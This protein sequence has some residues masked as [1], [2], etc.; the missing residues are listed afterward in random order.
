MKRKWSGTQKLNNHTALQ[1]TVK[2][3]VK[4]LECNLV[5]SPL[6]HA[7]ESPWSGFANTKPPSPG[8]CSTNRSLN[9]NMNNKVRDRACVTQNKLQNTSASFPKYVLC[10]NIQYF[11]DVRNMNRILFLAMTHRLHLDFSLFL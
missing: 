7:A 4:V 9:M 2:L 11:Y 1:H 5:R 3:V 6:M 8:N 10:Y